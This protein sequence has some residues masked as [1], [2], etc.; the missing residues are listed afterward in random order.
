MVGNGNT[1]WDTCFAK[2]RGE[3]ETILW[4]WRSEHGWSQEEMSLFSMANFPSSETSF[5][6]LLYHCLC[7]DKTKTDIS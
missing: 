4:L 1:F 7:G 3:I 5:C 6:Q 2:V